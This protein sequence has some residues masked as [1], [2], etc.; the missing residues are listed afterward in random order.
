M[1]NIYRNIFN[2]NTGY[3]PRIVKILMVSL[4]LFS[5]SGIHKG[6]AQQT[7]K[8]IVNGVVRD[9]AG[10]T[11]VGVNV[12]IKGT[13]IGTIT[14]VDGEYS[15]PVKQNDV[16]LFRFV[17]Y[18][19]QQI[20]FEG[21]TTINVTLKTD[22]T[23]LEEVVVVG[24]GE[25]K[26]ANLLGSISSMSS[27]EIQDI[28]VTNLTDLLEGRMAGV[29][30]APYQPTGNP[31]ASTRIQIRTET[32]FGT[33]GGTRK[34]ASPLYIV[35]GFIVT[36]EEWDV[37]DQSVIESFSVL[38]DASAAVYGSAGA[39][40]VILVKTKRGKEGKISVNYAGSFGFRDA[41]TQTEMLSAY[42]H[43]RMINARYRYYPDF[44]EK[45]MF[46]N[47]ELEA[48]RGLNNDWLNEAWQPSTESKNNITVSG[49][50][51]RL[52]Y[53]A[54]GVYQYTEGNFPNMGIGKHSY[55]LGIDTK[56]TDNLKASV[57]LA[58]D[59]RD[60]KRP[61]MTSEGFDT[62]EGLFK[63]L[64]QAP[65]WTPTHINELPVANNIGSNPFEMFNTRSY[66]REVDKGNTLN[67]KLTYEFQNKLKGLVA[68][69]TYSRREGHSYNKEYQIPFDTYT[70]RLLGDYN[71]VLSD[72]VETIKS[73][74]KN[75]KL[76]ESFSYSQRY[77][78]NVNLNYSKEIGL[79]SL[80]AFL[81]YEQ[82]EGSGY[83]FNTVAQNM[84][85][86]NLEILEAF[87]Y[88]SAI[89]KGSLSESGELGSVAR[90][91]YAYA[92]KYLMESTLR[93]ENTT[94]FA[95][96]YRSGLF[97][98]ISLGWV[99]SK[100]DFMRDNLAFI[101]YMKIRGS[102]GLTGYKSLGDYEYN[103]SYGPSG[104]Y[105][106]GDG[107]MGGMSVSGKSDVVSTGV[108]W[109]KSRMQNYGIDLKFLDSRLS[110][111][112]DGFYT[113]QY[114]ILTQRT[115]ELPEASGITQ[116]PSE[117]LG[118]LK[119]WGYDMEIGYHGKPSKDFS[120]DINGIFNFGT[121]RYIE[122]PNKWPVNDYRYEIGQS[123]SAAGREEG[124]TTNG[125]VRSQD[126]LAEINKEWN[127][128]WGHNY[129]LFGVDMG[130]VPDEG[131][132]FLYFQDIGRKGDV[133]N[134][135]PS[136][137]FEPDGMITENDFGYVERTND[138]LVWKNLLP[139]SMNM[140]LRY[141][142]FSFSMLWTMS[143]GITNYVTDKLARQAAT[144]SENT[145]AFWS[146]FWSVDN[147]N[148][149]YP[150]PLYADLNGRV[151]TFWMK[152][153]KSLR[154]RTVNISYSVP[155]KISMK[156]G[157]PSLRFY[158][159]GS[160]LWTPIQTFDYKEDAIARYNTYPLMRT[161]T[162]GVN[163]NL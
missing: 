159:N 112:I 143:Y 21:K 127:E 152:D 85:I 142:E 5:I 8:A 118:I 62:M 119:A 14:N 56:I 2:L 12:I 88:E 33:S 138:K 24:Y 40:G 84:Q 75:D 20:T 133:L 43:A 70:F 137:V 23:D 60:F 81:T 154:L 103:L 63:T 108:S 47:E 148:G 162:F 39:N 132:G 93:W 126:Q 26:R 71:Y 49:G 150:N 65:K 22:V 141:K 42:D 100:E 130:N 3:L 66:K 97:P 55:R 116:M 68:S 31:G 136:T 27:Q 96:G 140:N 25:V 50:N 29:S 46:S 123:T 161:F 134:G 72:E 105:L 122:M 94:R 120:W 59:N 57:T 41:T 149:A 86:P 106:F 160:N 76:A 102:F 153:V 19:S 77:Q 16:L 139:V 52:T 64:L 7:Q 51:D 104:S 156:V 38:K 125:I 78:L 58:I 35:D 115:V 82:K 95:P 129:S 98:A 111:A 1:N 73:N 117:N 158:L 13:T 11:L 37:M 74:E 113:Y 79:H 146:D 9:E 44:E 87:N 10:E 4:L 163:I 90:F 91:N 34:E 15:I 144:Q 48:V 45:Y 54:S 67:V 99:L 61:F 17:G 135:E 151:S 53:F 121:N 28:P 124:Y 83:G 69:A 18:T 6:K 30:V 114:D 128:K 155:K 110:V 107:T 157:I 36:Q 92:D 101:N 147:P 109:E 32:T 89:S 80:S 131:L 145:P